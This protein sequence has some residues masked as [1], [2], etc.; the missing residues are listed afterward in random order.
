METEFIYFFKKQMYK[1]HPPP[2]API[3]MFSLWS[4]HTDLIE[5][6]KVDST[7]EQVAQRY[8][9]ISNIEDVHNPPGQDLERSELT[10]KS[11]EGKSAGS[12]EPCPTRVTQVTQF[13]LHL[14]N[15][16]AM[17]YDSDAPCSATQ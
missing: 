1:Q 5:V 9:G 2:H 17:R 3:F 13:L 12:M 14:R 4:A 8:G 7:Q 15:I 16:P 10:S 6:N 11:D